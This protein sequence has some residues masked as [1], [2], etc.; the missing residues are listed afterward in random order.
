MSLF[1]DIKLQDMKDI[2]SRGLN[3]EA[4]F[5]KTILVTGAGG[6][7]ASYLVDFLLYL[8]STANAKICIIGLVRNLDKAKRRFEGFLDDGFLKLISHDVSTPYKTA[9]PID[10]II[11]AASNAS[12]KYYGVDPVGTATPNSIGTYYLLELAREKKSAGFLFVSSG[13]VYG[14]IPPERIPIAENDYGYIDPAEVR[15]CYAE[16]KRLGETLCVCYNYQ[17]KVP[18]KIVRPFHTYGP[19]MELNDGRVFS[20]FVANV[21]KSE[22]IVMKSD[23]SARRPYC[24]I[25][26]AISGF[27]AVLLNGES[28]KAYNLGNPSQECSVL[29]LAEKLVSLFPGKRLVVKQVERKNE[30]NYI[31]S[32]I[33][34]NSPQIERIKSLGWSPIHSIETGF[35]RTVE[36]YQNVT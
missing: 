8:N 17:F 36:S 5:G 12:P 4:L 7:L 28:G 10:Y 3:Y 33:A 1:K 9:L 14:Q 29:E 6:F 23:G 34:R 24:Y 2:E 21:V 22:N 32:P 20:D 18:A 30:A 35:K 11:H 16:S 27:I 25:T 26:D 13:E 15:S 19:G 31:A